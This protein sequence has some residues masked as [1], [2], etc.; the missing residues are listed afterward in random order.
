MIPLESTAL[1]RSSIDQFSSL[2]RNLVHRYGLPVSEGRR[3]TQAFFTH[4]RA[5]LSDFRTPGVDQ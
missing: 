3:S 1:V 2:D 4:R 5:R